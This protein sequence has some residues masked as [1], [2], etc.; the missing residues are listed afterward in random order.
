MSDKRADWRYIINAH[1]ALFTANGTMPTS[2]EVEAFIRQQNMSSD[3]EDISNVGRA[4]TAIMREIRRKNPVGIQQHS[5]AV[6]DSV[7]ETLVKCGK[8]LVKQSESPRPAT[9]TPVPPSIKQT[10]KIDF[11]ARMAALEENLKNPN[12]APSQKD[13]TLLFFLRAHEKQS[14]MSLKQFPPGIPVFAAQPGGADRIKHLIA[15]WEQHVQSRKWGNTKHKPKTK[16]PPR[17]RRT[18]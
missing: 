2:H 16:R 9:T 10:T 15:Q 4:L 3:I 17:G 5:S 7:Q 6:P 1:R 14:H 11:P 12:F 13:H 8:D 18:N